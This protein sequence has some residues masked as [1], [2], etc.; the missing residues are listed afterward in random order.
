MR[1]TP[2]CRPG[3]GAA[4]CEEDGSCLLHLLQVGVFIRHTC[5]RA[6][7]W[8]FSALKCHIRSVCPAQGNVGTGQ[9]LV[10]RPHRASH[11]ARPG[12]GWVLLAPLA[13]VGQG[14]SAGAR[15]L[16]TPTGQQSALATHPTQRPLLTAELPQRM[17]TR[18]H[19][20]TVFPPP[21]DSKAG[22][23]L[24]LRLP[25]CS[26]FPEQQV[27]LRAFPGHWG[28]SPPAGLDTC[29]RAPS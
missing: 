19:S 2:R 16:L 6:H 5:L 17:D 7:M 10:S 20:G 21:P 18:C 1:R 14:R 13:A 27:A 9:L 15:G 4:P 25:A 24:S 29:P 12:Q 3:E 22:D 23:A 26:L 11:Q 28:A 8:T